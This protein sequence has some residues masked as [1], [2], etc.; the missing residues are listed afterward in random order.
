MKKLLILIL[1]SCMCL[2]FG[3][4]MT[5]CDLS[6]TKPEHI[7][8]YDKQAV[9]EEYL[10]EEASCISKAVYYFSCEC[11]EKGEETFESGEYAEHSVASSWTKGEGKHWH[12]CQT[13]GCAAKFD[14]EIHTY[15]DGVC[16]CG[17]SEPVKDKDDDDDK[18]IS[19]TEW[20]NA[21]SAEKLSNITVFADLPDYQ[22]YF[23]FADGTAKVTVAKYEDAE[24]YCIA[25]T[26]YTFDTS[27]NTYAK[28]T[29]DDK[30][31]SSVTFVAEFKSAFL[32]TPDRYSDIRYEADKDRFC[33]N[34]DGEEYVVTIKE[35]NVATFVRSVGA[36]DGTKVYSYTLTQYGTTAIT[37]P[38]D[39][40]HVCSFEEIVSEEFLVEEATCASK[41]VYKKS[42]TCGKVGTETFE[43]G[44]YTEDHIYDEEGVCTVCRQG[45]YSAGLLFTLIS[46]KE[47]Y[48][49]VAKGTC[50]DAEV[51]IP[52]TYRNLPVKK[53]EQKAFKNCT[54][55]T[56]V[57]IP[58]SVISIGDS[59]FSGCNN[60][61][62][63]TLPF[64]GASATA[65]SVYDQVFGYI[66][67]YTTGVGTVAGATIQCYYNA[68]N[69]HYYIPSGLSTVVVTDGKSIPANAFRGCSAITSITLPDTV[70]KIS[71]RA[72]SDCSSLESIEIP[73]G[74]TEIGEDAFKGCEAI[75]KV[76][77]AGTA[78]QWAKIYFG[79]QTYE[80]NNYANQTYTSFANPTY[81]TKDLYIQ[82]E[83]LT[84][85]RLTEGYTVS[86][87]AFYGCKSLKSVELSD[88]IQSIG[89]SAFYGCSLLEEI[90][91]P[92]NVKSV[93]IAA[94]YGCSG[95]K[96]VTIPASV[97]QINSFAFCRCA[98][99]ERVNYSGTAD[100]WA[101]IK[102]DYYGQ[103]QKTEFSYSNPAYQG[104]LYINGELL[105]EAVLSTAER[106]SDY[107]FYGCKGLKRVELS[108]KVT[109][110][111]TYAFYGCENMESIEIAGA[112][113][114]IKAYTFFKCKA[115]TSINI[116]A[117][118][119]TIG[120]YAFSNCSSL[121]ALEIPSAVKSIG[122][123]AF[124]NCS[125]LN[126]VTFQNTSGWSVVNAAGTVI[127]N[128]VNLSN[129]SNNAVVL[130]DA[131][132][133][134]TWKRT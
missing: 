48:Y 104:D 26:W 20:E 34:L 28:T 92:Q 101:Q 65:N 35:G 49:C 31:Y 18:K 50:S 111:G 113:T 7:H 19:K 100:D 93:G 109:A 40:T 27:E 120:T 17:E 117:T 99:L 110:I 55:M 67:G 121:T 5:A 57:T 61:T 132:S 89:H 38:F 2:F 1:T 33:L 42:C 84:E 44:D 81:Y 25:D 15:I 71:D 127:A 114:G 86:S 36:S 85:L 78:D 96:S 60:L 76:N 74:V 3:I 4:A 134:A 118:V 82:G 47:D 126:S 39:P 88:S 125:N 21:F 16:V 14:E 119:T 8:T 29:A 98:A 43:Y 95:L 53:I 10:K 9:S 73:S 62:K 79:Y 22:G 41:A 24:L 30:A 51:I 56:S 69:Y 45:Y 46:E 94:F 52:A 105:E 103:I 133:Y 59:A 123:Y 75:T 13:A 97:N 83:L 128:Q 129:T 122:G 108:E 58:N 130:R 107:A 116:P 63:I 80:L 32:A 115:L 102:F 112:I 23:Y 37:V 72:F 91:L 68:T 131:Y 70:N 11:G 54:T 77:Y 12:V 66:F 90:I 106:V 124:S 64:V 87:F 6:G